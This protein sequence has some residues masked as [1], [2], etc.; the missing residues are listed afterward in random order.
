MN[1]IVFVILTIPMNFKILM[2]YTILIILMIFK[3]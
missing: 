3:I 1:F 2:I